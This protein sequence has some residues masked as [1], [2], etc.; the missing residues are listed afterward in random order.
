MSEKKKKKVNNSTDMKKKKKDPMIVAVC[1]IGIISLIALPVIGAT[2]LRTEKPDNSEISANFGWNRV[3]DV[4]F[5]IDP[6]T[7]QRL[8][9]LH[10]IEGKVYFFDSNG[11]ITP[12][13]TT[14]G[15]HQIYVSKE[16]VIASGLYKIGSDVFYFDEGNYAMVTGFKSVDGN[17]YCFRED[18]KAMTDFQNID[19]TYSFNWTC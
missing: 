19:G 8:T 6:N 15:G 7:Q 9:G 5:Y 16:G 13:W 17:V 10:E 3:D 1:S 2:V 18:G 11:G 14:Y 12:G 4:L